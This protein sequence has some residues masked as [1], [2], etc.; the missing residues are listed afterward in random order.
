MDDDLGDLDEL[1]G[2]DYHHGGDAEE[3]DP[4]VKPKPAPAPKG[5]IESITESSI[6]VRFPPQKQYV[7]KVLAQAMPV[8][9]IKDPANPFASFGAGGIEIRATGDPASATEA[10][11]SGL[12]SGTAYIC[13]LVLT[14]PAGTVAGA[15]SGKMI[16]KCSV[17]RAPTFHTSKANSIF[18]RFESQGKQGAQEVSR[19][20]IGVARAGAKDPFDPTNKPGEMSDGSPRCGELKQARIQ[21]LRAGSMYCFRLVVHN[22]AGKVIGETSKPML[23][24]PGP[25]SRLRE[26]S[27]ARK[28]D[29]VHLRFEP[30]YQHLTKLQVQYT[31]IEGAKATF[32]QLMKKNGKAAVIDDP[33]NATDIEIKGLEG[34]KKYVFRLLSENSSG[35]NIGPILG[36]ITTVEHAPDMLDKSG[37]MTILPKM[38]GKKTLGRRLSIRKKAPGEKHWFVIDGRLLNWFTDTNCKDEVDFLHLSKLKRITYMPDADGQARQFS[39]DLKDGSKI[40]L[41]CSSSDPNVTTHDYTM[42]W[43]TAIQ[44]SLTAQPDEETPKSEGRRASILAADDA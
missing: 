38:S 9:M 12:R 5:V 30:H 22:A 7:T 23:T 35:R 11:M 44:N 15:V 4:N 2:D 16:T 21:K 13:R 29:S 41:E 26:D 39:L 25:A 27:S 43:M 19:L 40:S 8:L 37:W 33:Q 31:K 1:M 24:A 42:S 17:P 18:I 28:S 32:E 34:N 36:P 10:R 3:G 14:N 20:T 6:L